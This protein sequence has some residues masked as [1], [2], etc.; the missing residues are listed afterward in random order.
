MPLRLRIAAPSLKNNELRSRESRRRCRPSRST[1]RSLCPAF[2]V[3]TGV[4]IDN[5]PASPGV[6]SVTANRVAGRTHRA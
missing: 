1:S 4:V 2:M 3:S 5:L 6:R